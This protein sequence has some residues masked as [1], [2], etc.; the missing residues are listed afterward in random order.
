MEN[1]QPQKLTNKQ[2]AFVSEYLRDFNATQA[3]IR[4]G[5]SEKSARSTGWENLQKPEIEEE[6]KRLVSEK[7]MG[8]DEVLIRLAD[9]ARGDISDLMALSPAGF[10]FELMVKNENGELVPNPKTK[11]IKKIR[12]KI[13]TYLSK[14]DDGEDREVVETELELYSAHEAL[15]DIGRHMKLFTDQVQISG[16]MGLIWDMPTPESQT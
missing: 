12:Q 14:K 11:L 13:T 9:I 6:I 7:S 16:E 4:A 10:S 3:A 1:S 8:A 15:R 5:Y 2:A